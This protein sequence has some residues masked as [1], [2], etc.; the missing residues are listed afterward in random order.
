MT[1]ADVVAQIETCGARPFLDIVA[2]H[3][4]R[5]L[6]WIQA[7]P[8]LL[9]Y[10]QAHKDFVCGPLSALHPRVGTPRIDLRAY[11]RSFGPRALQFVINPDTG[12]GDVDLDRFNP[13]ED[14]VSILGHAGEVVSHRLGRLFRRRRSSNG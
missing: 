4:D 5:P 13:Y 10:L 7:K 3:P 2:V 14:V 9:P 6:V 12:V 11:R 1:G 8:E